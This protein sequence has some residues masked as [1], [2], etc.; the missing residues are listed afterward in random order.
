MEK[1]N[2]RNQIGGTKLEELKWRNQI[3][4]TKLEKPNWRNQTGG[5]IL[6]KPNRRNQIGE[7]KSENPNRR[8]QIGETKLENPNWRCRTGVARLPEGRS[9]RHSCRTELPEPDDILLHILVCY[10]DIL[11]YKRNILKLLMSRRIAP[12]TIPKRRP[13]KTEKVN[14]S[15]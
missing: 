4:E 3:G 14:V 12:L 7:T 10:H 15:A 6:E 1:P 8:A 13:H 5:T 9:Q 11:K 2:W